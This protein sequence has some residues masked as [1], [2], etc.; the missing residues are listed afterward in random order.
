MNKRKIQYQV[1]PPKNNAE[2]AANMEDVPE[3]YEKAY[4][5]SHPVICMDEPP[6]QSIKETRLPEPATKDHPRRVDYEYEL[7]EPPVFSCLPNLC[8][9]G[10]WLSPVPV[11]PR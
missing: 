11:E 1:I 9:A 10:V 3:T 2:F 4:N 7:T 8:Q 6:V 5:P